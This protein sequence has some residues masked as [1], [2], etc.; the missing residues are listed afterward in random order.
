MR[1]CDIMNRQPVKIGPA[2]TVTEAVAL[3]GQSQC[4]D[5]MVVGDDERF[6]GVLSEG[7]LIRACLPRKGEVAQQADLREA[8]L[9]IFCRKAADLRDRT[10][11]E[12]ILSPQQIVKLAPNSALLDAAGVMVNKQIRRLPVVDGDKL[13]GA[14]SRA[15]LLLG[16]LREGS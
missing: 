4:S 15:D 2:A 7:D 11:A 5:L 1:V 3:L 12:Y 16:L 13:V 6:L 9:E 10:I 8:A 14:V